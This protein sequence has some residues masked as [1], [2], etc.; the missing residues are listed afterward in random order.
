MPPPSLP[1][2]VARGRYAVLLG[3]LDWI[4]ALPWERRSEGARLE[5][6]AARALLDEEHFGL[7]KVNAPYCPWPRGN[8]L[9][10]PLLTARGHVA[11]P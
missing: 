2:L 11:M 1:P 9:S 7:E 8:A 3:Y 6:K 5:M 4:S 10:A